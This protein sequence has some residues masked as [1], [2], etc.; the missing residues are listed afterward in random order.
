MAVAKGKKDIYTSCMGAQRAEKAEESENNNTS[1]ADESTLEIDLPRWA[2][3]LMGATF[4]LIILYD[5][6]MWIIKRM[7]F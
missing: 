1:T 5:I 3:E 4:A 2:W 6:T 7:F